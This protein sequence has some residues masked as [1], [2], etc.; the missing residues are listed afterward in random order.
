RQAL[1]VVDHRLE[2][3]VDAGEPDLLVRLIAHAPLSSPRGP[4]CLRIA[5]RRCMYTATPA[6]I[7]AR[8]AFSGRGSCGTGTAAVMTTNGVAAGA[9]ANRRTAPR[10][11]RGYRVASPRP[12]S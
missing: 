5:Y 11:D 6:G 9:A 4:G 12:R 3:H 2:R 7:G 1:R 10:L 8:C